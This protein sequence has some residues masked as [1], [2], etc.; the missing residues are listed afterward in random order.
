MSKLSNSDTCPRPTTGETYFPEVKQFTETPGIGI[1]RVFVLG[2]AVL[3]SAVVLAACA[4]ALA[5]GRAVEVW[6]GLGRIVASYHHS[7]SF[8]IPDSLRDSV[9]LSL[10]E[11]ATEPQVWGLVGL[12]VQFIPIVIA[13]TITQVFLN[14]KPVD[15]RP[16]GTGRARSHKSRVVLPLI[17]FIPDSLR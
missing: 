6:A 8:F 13:A 4:A 11:N 16:A 14:A 12:E 17:H 10:N 7:S 1:F 5:G 3:P 2:S 15:A 9:P